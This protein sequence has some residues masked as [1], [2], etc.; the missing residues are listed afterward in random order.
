MINFNLHALSIAVVHLKR[1]MLLKVFVMI[2]NNQ[3]IQTYR[4]NNTISNNAFQCELNVGFWCLSEQY[5]Q[6][7][8]RCLTLSRELHPSET[9]NWECWEIWPCEKSEG[10]VLANEKIFYRTG[11]I[12]RNRERECVFKWGWI[13]EPRGDKERQKSSRGWPQYPTSA[14]ESRQLS[15]TEHVTEP[16][17]PTIQSAPTTHGHWLLNITVLPTGSANGQLSRDVNRDRL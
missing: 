6:D 8:I 4:S 9:G 12:Q 1:V 10:G 3:L 17:C 2:T 13:E 5:S 16:P 11:C 14:R 7:Y 15:N